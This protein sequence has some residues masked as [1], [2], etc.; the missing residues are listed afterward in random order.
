MEDAPVCVA[1]DDAVPLEDEGARCFGDSVCEGSILVS[2]LPSGIREIEEFRK[3][4]LLFDFSYG[5]RPH[6][7][8]LAVIR[9]ERRIT[10]H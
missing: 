8:M 3:G 6:L 7:L 10:Y 2:V 1:A 4:S 9:F 5:A